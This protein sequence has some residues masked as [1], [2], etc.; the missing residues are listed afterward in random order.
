MAKLQPLESAGGENLV[1][2]Q[3]NLASSKLILVECRFITSVETSVRRYSEIARPKA[4][5]LLGIPDNRIFVDSITKLFQTHRRQ[6]D[7][8]ILCLL[9]YQSGV[10]RANG[11][12]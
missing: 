3:Y 10:K 11:S 2:L 8:Q 6:K 9:S 1:T 5:F 7:R 4:I 12:R